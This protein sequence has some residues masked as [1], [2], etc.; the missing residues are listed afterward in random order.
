MTHVGVGMRNDQC[1]WDKFDSNWYFN[2]N[3]ASVRD[4]DRQILAQMSQF[5]ADHLK[6]TR[7][8][9]GVDVGSGTNL[10]PALTMLP[11]CQSITLWE[12]SAANIAWL[13]REIKS[14]RP[15]W[16]AFWRQLSRLG[17]SRGA[18]G[19]ARKRLAASAMVCRGNIFELPVQHWDL[20]TMFFVAESI[21]SD[22]AEFKR[23]TRHFVQSL[24]AGAPFAAAFMEKSEGYLVGSYRYPAVPVTIDDIHECLS[25]LVDT[26]F[27]VVP[28]KSEHPLREGYS[29]TMLLALGVAK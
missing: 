14:F 7:S 21:T 3:Y 13:H 26:D 18:A 24:K 12:R 2:H 10:Y 19:N 20:G 28:I 1:E 25:D 17:R 5:F 8:Q 6:D 22:Y 11:F 27:S 9:H 16:D 15:S 29:G 4:D 23:A